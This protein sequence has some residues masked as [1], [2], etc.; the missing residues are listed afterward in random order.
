MWFAIFEGIDKKSY[1]LSSCST[2]RPGAETRAEMVNRLK[3]HKGRLVR[4]GVDK[5][6]Y[7]YRIVHQKDLPKYGIEMR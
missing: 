5:K 4:N 3:A 7:C 2:R 6:S 1:Q